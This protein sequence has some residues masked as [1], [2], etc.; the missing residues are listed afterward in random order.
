[1]PLNL[2]HPQAEFMN[3]STPFSGFVGGYRSGKT[4][5]G[6]VKLWKLAAAYP[7][8]KLGYFAPT[9]PQ[10][11]D[12]FY[13]TIEEV[14]VEFSDHAGMPCTVD[15]NKSEHTVKL[16]IGGDVY[17]TVKCRSME[18]P[19]RIVGF[20]ISH[21]LIDEIDCMKKEKADAAW[22]KIVAR[23]SS[24]RDD[25]PVNTVDFTTTPEG[26]NWMYEFFVKQLREKPELKRFYSLV[27]ASTLKN[28]KNLP[29]DYIDKLYAT[30]PSNLVD[31]YVNGEFVNLTSGG[32]Y[33][34]YDRKLNN[35]DRIVKD[36]DHLHIGMDF[37][38]GKMS[39]IVHVEDKVDEVKITSAVDEFMGLLD[40]PAMIK[41][42]ETKYPNHRITI[43]PDAS[44][45]NR[46]SS[47]A[48]ETDIS[49]LKKAFKVNAKTK[50][51]FVKDRIASVQGM[52]CNALD[53]RRYF[54]NDVTAP[55]TCESL[56]QQIYNKQGEPDKSHDNDHPNDA[57]GYYIHNQF[58]I[59]AK[60]GRLN[61]DG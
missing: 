39:A 28:R 38:V 17:A 45:Q 52:L 46:K 27:K 3:T 24:V 48:S 8:I 42:I 34:C 56:E 44:G 32:V 53:E 9:Y 21:A 15:I 51:P 41:A 7:G 61:I 10:V 29:D 16:I 47:N 22:K 35:T 4:F 25:Y 40:T 12:I 30:Y 1:M 11:R 43:Y 23:M 31:A 26:F 54:I 20:D 6:C 57:L 60:G 5:I 36:S 2:N 14:G 50:N 49:Q 13:D 18:H 33:T 37:N 58:P 19:H 59:R 55:E